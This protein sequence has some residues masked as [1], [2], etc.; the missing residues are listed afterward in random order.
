MLRK[1]DLLRKL[2]LWTTWT[3][4]TVFVKTL[5]S[6]VK[7][8]D[9]LQNLIWTPPPKKTEFI[10]KIVARS[11]NSFQYL[12]VNGIYLFFLRSTYGKNT[13]TK[14]MAAYLGNRNAPRPRRMLLL[15]TTQTRSVLSHA[16]CYFFYFTDNSERCYSF[17]NTVLS[18]GFCKPII[19]KKKSCFQQQLLDWVINNWRFVYQLY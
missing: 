17:I 14:K 13:V 1:L 10:K 2:N 7:S 3:T 6:L 19:D 11:Q 5:A 18:P 12:H 9:F 15:S 8:L 16:H 4:K